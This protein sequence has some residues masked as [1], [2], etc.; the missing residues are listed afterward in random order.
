MQIM[1]KALPYAV[2]ATMAGCS[3]AF[4]TQN[5]EIQNESDVTVFVTLGTLASGSVPPHASGSVQP[6]EGTKAEV[7]EIRL[8][9][10]PDSYVCRWDE[11]K[12]QMPIV[13]T[14]DGPD[15]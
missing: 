3:W 8:E 9:G 11:V 6:D 13:V 10:S 7:I 12:D 2:V 4:G 1:I 15:C 5:V 14:N